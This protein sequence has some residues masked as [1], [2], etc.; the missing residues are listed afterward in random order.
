M[1]AYENRLHKVSSRQKTYKWNE[2]S[3]ENALLENEK[4]LLKNTLLKTKIGHNDQ[5]NAA[6]LD[7]GTVK[8]NKQKRIDEAT[9]GKEEL[10]QVGDLFHDLCL[11]T[12]VEKIVNHCVVK[13]HQLR[14]KI[15]V[16]HCYH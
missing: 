9:G 11:K 12:T 4:L 8:L 15:K 2:I 13:P 7:M 3:D 10:G 16:P 5:F 1:T 14:S 6:F